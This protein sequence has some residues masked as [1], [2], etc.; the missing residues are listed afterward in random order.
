LRRSSLL[1]NLS[2]QFDSSQV[3]DCACFIMVSALTA[4]LL[5]LQRFSGSNSS[6]NAHRQPQTQQPITLETA[7][8]SSDQTPDLHQSSSSRSKSSKGEPSPSM[9][10]SQTSNNITT[11]PRANQPPIP[12]QDTLSSRQK[13]K[14]PQ[15]LS[16]Y[17]PRTTLSTMRRANQ[18]PIPPKDTL[19][20]RQ[21]SKAPQALSS[22]KPRTTLSSSSAALHRPAAL[23]SCDGSHSLKRTPMPAPKDSG[24]DGAEGDAKRQKA[25]ELAYVAHMAFRDMARGGLTVP[26]QLRASSSCP[27]VLAPSSGMIDM[28]RVSLVASKNFAPPPPPLLMPMPMP[29]KQTGPR[30]N[31]LVWD[32][33]LCASL[34]QA[35]SSLYVPPA[36]STSAS[37]TKLPPSS[38]TTTDTISSSSVADSSSDRCDWASGSNTMAEDSDEKDSVEENVSSSSTPDDEEQHDDCFKTPKPETH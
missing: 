35:T 37:I 11:M 38:C 6:M 19:S 28:S 25:D 9:V 10:S 26:S 30:S 16:S 32:D 17:K 3:I 12:P 8:R 15:A 1:H 18:P 31:S 34:I 20:S 24:G 4:R 27:R 22:Y 2:S 5:S 7:S 21:K 23:P 36:L 33:R 29:T 13:S 14:A